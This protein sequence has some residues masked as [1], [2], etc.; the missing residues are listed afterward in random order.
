MREYLF[1]GRPI[2]NGEFVEIDV[3]ISKDDF[4]YGNLIVDGK[5]AWIV[6]GVAESNSEYI[7]IEQWIPVRPETVGQY[8]GLKDKNGIEI[9]EGDIIKSGYSGSQEHIVCF[10]EYNNEESYEDNEQGYGWFTINTKNEVSSMICLDYHSNTEI[11]GN[12]H[13][14]E[15][16]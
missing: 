10:G 5:D 11:I 8:T 12:I 9:Y 4:V 16:V 1:R 2:S 15:V 13:E 14:I 7:A 6:N 3:Y